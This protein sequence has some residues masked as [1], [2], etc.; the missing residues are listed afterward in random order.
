MKP[1][2]VV[3][4]SFLIFLACSCQEDKLV[5][6]SQKLRYDQVLTSKEKEDTQLSF[7]TRSEKLTLTENP[8]EISLV[9]LRLK[10]Q[11]N[12]KLSGP[13]VKIGEEAYADSKLNKPESKKI[14]QQTNSMPP[15]ANA[16][17]II[18]LGFIDWLV[19]TWAIFLISEPLLLFPALFLFLLVLSFVIAVGIISIY[20]KNIDHNPELLNRLVKILRTIGIIL[21]ALAVVC[22]IIFVGNPYTQFILATMLFSIGQM[23]VMLGMYSLLFDPKIN[24]PIGIES[25]RVANRKAAEKAFWVIC[26]V[27]FFPTLL[28]IASLGSLAALG[29]LATIPFLIS[30]LISLCLFGMGVVVIGNELGIMN[31]RIKGRKIKEEGE[32]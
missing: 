5:L 19:Y 26:G 6:K 9:S 8:D 3:L 22:F 27:M 2:Y 18:L 20:D 30:I 25:K 12:P 21:I 10:I 16:N 15:R 24:R 11:E 17:G 29:T 7:S 4:I 28:L 13:S 32:G 31:I 14:Y 23:G 1:F